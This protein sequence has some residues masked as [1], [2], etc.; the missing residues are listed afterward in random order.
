[1]PEIVAHRCG[2]HGLA[3][4]RR[5]RPGPTAEPGKGDWG[6]NDDGLQCSLKKPGRRGHGQSTPAAKPTVELAAKI[7]PEDPL[8]FKDSKRYKD[9]F[10]QARKQTGERDALVVM[11]GKLAGLDV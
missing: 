9:R 7:E 4:S 11:A 10:A 6:V 3:D 2:A 5:Q 8:K 1:M